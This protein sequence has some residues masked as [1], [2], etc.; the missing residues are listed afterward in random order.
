M[1]QNTEWAHPADFTIVLGIVTT[2]FVRARHGY[3][4]RHVSFCHEDTSPLFPRTA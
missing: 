1:K 2:N 3:H 4:H